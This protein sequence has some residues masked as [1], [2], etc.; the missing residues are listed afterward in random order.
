MYSLN[1]VK[2]PSV[3]SSCKIKAFSCWLG[4]RIY[5]ELVKFKVGKMFQDEKFLPASVLISING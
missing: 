3:L 5:N 2:Q 1:A 4:R